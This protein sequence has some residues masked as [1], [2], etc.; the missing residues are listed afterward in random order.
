MAQYILLLRGVNVGGKHALSMADIKLRLSGLGCARPRSYINSGNLIFHSEL[1]LPELSRVLEDMLKAS[2]P[3]PIP[4]ALLRAADY[5]REAGRLPDWWREPL[6]RRDVLFFTDEI[7]RAVMRARI[8]AMPLFNEVLHF[9]ELGVFWGKYD[10]KE[11]LKTAYH[12]KL[13]KE[14]YYR[15]ITIRNGNTFDKLLELLEEGD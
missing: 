14:P 10:E 12:R 6:A 15:Q 2:Y 11:F 1:D 3:F 13:M 8:A 4:F 7:D 5:R 9:G